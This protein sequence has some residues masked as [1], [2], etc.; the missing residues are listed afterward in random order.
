MTQL[1]DYANR[2]VNVALRR[3]EGVLEMRLHTAGGPLI[4]SESAHRELGDAFAEVG[5]DRENR[6]VILTGTG[7]AF[8]N[9]SD[10]ASFPSLSTPQA[11]D[12]IYWEGRRLLTTLLDIEAPVIAA[13]NGPAT[14]H[15]GLALV[16]D[17]VLASETA[18]FQ[19]AGHFTSGVVP[20]DG[21][22]VIW[23][24][25]LGHNRGKYFLLTGQVLTAQQLHALGVINEV[26][27]PAE[28]LPRAW[29]LARELAK[30][31]PLTLRYTRLVL[32]YDLRRRLREA[33]EHGLALEGL[34]TIAQRQERA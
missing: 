7:D 13:I 21:V 11:W 15:A 20:G 4:W 16:A 19:D 23:P 24:L 30:K 17:I 29:A 9:A 26:L 10:S 22:Q 28:L 12:K 5:A 8:C 18:T 6:V 14:R 3:E 32:N 31:P 25:L 33:L 27:P 34:A 1:A 2:Y